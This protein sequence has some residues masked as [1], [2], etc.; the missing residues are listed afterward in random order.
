VRD[1][2]LPSFSADVHLLSFFMARWNLFYVCLFLIMEREQGSSYLESVLE[3]L[4]QTYKFVLEQYLEPQPYPMSGLGYVGLA[5]ISCQKMFVF[6]GDLARYR[7]MALDT[8]NY[9]KAKSWYT[10]AN[11]AN[12]KNG[13]PYNQLAI[14]ALYAVR[15]FPPLSNS[16]W[17][18]FRLVTP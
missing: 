3:M 8:S 18:H 1:P 16:N 5:V 10:K 13:R 14:L 9:G 12:P 2:V 6:M 11:L 4:Q 15:I 7:E 17:F